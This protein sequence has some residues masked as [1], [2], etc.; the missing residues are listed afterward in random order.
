VAPTLTLTPRDQSGAAAA[1][2]LYDVSVSNNDGPSCAASQFS[3]AGVVPAGWS[4]VPSQ[5]SVQLAPSTSAQLSW[6]VASA[7]NAAPGFYSVSLSTTDTNTTVHSASTVGSYTVVQPC[8]DAPTVNLSPSNQTASSGAKVNYVIDL[9]NRDRAGC[10]ATTFVLAPTVPS[11]W[12][13]SLSAATLTLSPGASGASTLAVTSPAAAS[14]GTYGVWTYVS[15][16]GNPIHDA[17]KSGSYTVP[18]GDTAPPAAPGGLTATLRRKQVAV[19]W[20]PATDN[21]GV[22]G[23]RVLRNGLAIA[24]T[25]ATSWTDTAVATGVPYT[26]SVVAF[27]AAGNTSAPSNAATVTIAGGG[28]K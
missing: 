6:R 12:T 27:D 14:A 25:T 10:P 22:V 11:G 7:A 9:T 17:A 24:T 26:Y 21:V 16:G 5:S 1:E 28:K 19:A 18:A 8:L 2:A 23:Y 13:A 15:G 4:S 20:R 3:V